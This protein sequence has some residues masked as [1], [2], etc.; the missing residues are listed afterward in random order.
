MKLDRPFVRGALVLALL[1]L[2]SAPPLE[3]RE[4]GSQEPAPAAAGFTLGER[5]RLHAP[6]TFSIPGLFEGRKSRV[7]VVKEDADLLTLARDPAEPLVVIRPGRRITGRL[8]SADDGSLTLV[9][10]GAA[11]PVRLDRA[12]VARVEFSDGRR[13]RVGRGALIGAFAGAAVGALAGMITYNRYPNGC[14]EGSSASGC[15]VYGAVLFGVPGA[16]I[17]ALSSIGPRETWREAPL[18]S[19][20][21][22]RPTTPRPGGLA[23]ALTIRF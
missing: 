7:R 5:V 16:A 2:L 9:P 1:T 3:A 11:E 17:G 18:A 10:E 13:S 8:V 15:A 22:S 12:S 4:A 21:S 19:P 20:A 23:F 14:F 6:D